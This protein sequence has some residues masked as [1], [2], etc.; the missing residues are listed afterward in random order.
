MHASY[1]LHFSDH[2]GMFLKNYQKIQN[3]NNKIRN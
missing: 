1:Q 2:V 3:R